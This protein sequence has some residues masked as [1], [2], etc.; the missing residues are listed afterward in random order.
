LWGERKD[1]SSGNEVQC[2]TKK[3]GAA[4]SVLQQEI[5]RVTGVDRN[6]EE[7]YLNLN[8]KNKDLAGESEGM[9]SELDS[10]R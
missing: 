4:V 5:G 9:S 3:L 10:V 8:S 1:F 2:Q 6:K 7:Q